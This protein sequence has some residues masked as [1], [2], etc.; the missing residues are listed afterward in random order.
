MRAFTAALT[1]S[2]AAG[3]LV[4]AG[5]P[6]QADGFDDETI[7]GACQGNTAEFRFRLYYNSGT[8]G[9]YRDFRYAVGNFGS[10]PLT[11]S[12]NYSLKFCPG[13]G[14]G[15]GQDVK[16]NAASAR[17]SHTSYGACVYYSSWFDGAMDSIAPGVPTPRAQ[18]LVKTYNE[19]A[20]FQWC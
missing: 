19:N 5:T 18:N 15:A 13:T 7:Q 8:A 16:N 4:F 1:A 3:F 11:A 2:V 17:N 14:A 20:S 12:G 10:V 9:A 6:A